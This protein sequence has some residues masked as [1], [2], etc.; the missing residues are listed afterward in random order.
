MRSLLFRRLTANGTLSHRLV[1]IPDV[2]SLAEVVIAAVRRFVILT[3]FNV[4]AAVGGHLVADLRSSR[5]TVCAMSL[6]STAGFVR[7]TSSSSGGGMGC[8]GAG[9][10]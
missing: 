6:S 10:V 9:A 3:V 2:E 4:A 8:G 5:A 1:L 7:T